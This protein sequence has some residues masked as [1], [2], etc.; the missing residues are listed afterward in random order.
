MKKFYSEL[1][2]LLES[3]AFKCFLNSDKIQLAQVNAL[4]SLL[5]KNNIDFDTIFTSKSPRLP[6]TL[7]ITVV[8]NSLTRISRTFTF[9]D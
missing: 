1:S 7:T 8:I 2:C 9:S 3:E 6:A 4:T 5:I